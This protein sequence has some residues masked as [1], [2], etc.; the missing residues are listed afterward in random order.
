[1]WFL[2]SLTN[3]ESVMK[4]TLRK[5]ATVAAACVIFVAIVPLL[6]SAMLVYAHCHGGGD[7]K[8]C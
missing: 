3:M 4:K 1:M 8:N 7:I 5:A 6:A 2:R